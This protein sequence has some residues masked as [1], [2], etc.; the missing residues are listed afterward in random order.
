MGHRFFEIKDV[1]CVAILYDMILS[2]EKQQC[3]LIKYVNDIKRQV[4]SIVCIN[5]QVC[6]SVI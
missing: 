6:F 3:H 5:I 1:R 2:A 4:Q